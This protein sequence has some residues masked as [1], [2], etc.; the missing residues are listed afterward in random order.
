MQR[1]SNNKL[2]LRLV[3]LLGYWAFITMFDA[4]EMIQVKR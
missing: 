4:D 1:W 2:F 3:G